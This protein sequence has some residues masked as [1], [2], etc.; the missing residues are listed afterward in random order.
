MDLYYNR[1]MDGS[2]GYPHLRDVYYGK[3]RFPWEGDR[4]DS[5]SN[6]DCGSRLQQSLNR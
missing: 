5:N 2:Q 3:Q 1:E 6:D 4:F